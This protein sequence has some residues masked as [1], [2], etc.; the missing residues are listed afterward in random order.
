MTFKKGIVPWNKGKRGLGM[1]NYGKKHSLEWNK[2]ISL[3]HKKI[4]SPWLIGKRCSDETKEKISKSHIGK[5]KSWS[6][7]PILILENNPW[8]KG[9]KVS[10]SALHAWV[11]RNKGKADNCINC[12]IKNLK[13]YHWANIDHK[14]RRNLE[15]YISL[16]PKCHG[17]YDKDL[18]G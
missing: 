7:F 13:R 16:C 1:A 6:K 2:K 14:Y 15:D 4:G 3:S 11:R 17:S 12:N 18:L 5:K 10:Y 8:W 9:E